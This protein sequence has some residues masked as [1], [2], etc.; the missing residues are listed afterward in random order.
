MTRNSPAA[1]PVV[2]VREN[3][4]ASR[5]GEAVP[6][7]AAVA[8]AAGVAEAEGA[9]RDDDDDPSRPMPPNTWPTS[10]IG[11]WLLLDA[12]AVRLCKV[13]ANG[14]NRFV[15]P[16]VLDC[17]TELCALESIPVCAKVARRSP[18]CGAVAAREPATR[19]ASRDGEDAPALRFF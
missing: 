13:S 18:R 6:P 11:E 4:G 3:I 12:V 16:L 14:C 9:S 19:G 7:R 17:A 10:L 8:A 15:L 1:Q 2:V 5:V